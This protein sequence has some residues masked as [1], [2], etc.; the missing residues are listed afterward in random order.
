[1]FIIEAGKKLLVG[2]INQFN[3]PV[4][5]LLNITVKGK[6]TVAI[7]LGINRAVFIVVII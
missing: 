4:Y 1:M 6:D 2:W 7:L 5:I 3:I